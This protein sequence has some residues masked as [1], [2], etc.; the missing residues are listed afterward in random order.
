MILTSRKTALLMGLA[1]SLSGCSL[2]Q[3]TPQKNT[4]ANAEMKNMRDT[5]SYIIGLQ[6]AEE[7]KEFAREYRT[8]DTMLL[9]GMMDRLL[10]STMA[11]DR[12]QAE[13]VMERYEEKRERERERAEAEQSEE[14][15]EMSRAEQNLKKS[16]QF[17]ERNL[18]KEGVQRTASG[19]QYKV[20]EKGDGATPGPKE[21]VKVHY[22]GKLIDGTVFDNSYERGAPATF[23]VNRVIKGWQEGLQLMKAGGKYKFYIPP[24]LGYGE[25]GAGEK[26]GPNEVLIFTVKLL[27]VK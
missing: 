18:A 10:D 16:R 4:L 22:K 12:E 26:I 14:P 27:A 23:Q 15:E 5:A 20:L 1:L 25:S 11:L 21:R 19:L 2:F 24:R 7:G 3:S 8:N 9:K 6:L 17:L 13:R